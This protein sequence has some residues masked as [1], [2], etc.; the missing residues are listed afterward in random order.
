MFVALAVTWHTFPQH[1]EKILYTDC[2][3]YYGS[4]GL[5]TAVSGMEE[6][7]YCHK[8][9]KCTSSNLRTV[10]K[11]LF[12]ITNTDLFLSVT[13]CEKSHLCRHLR[14]EDACG[15]EGTALKYSYPRL[16]LGHF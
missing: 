12:T 3:E 7:I 6:A 10:V 16:R 4:A 9:G 11:H 15:R 5:V 13:Y 1:N 2:I 14:H 8:Y